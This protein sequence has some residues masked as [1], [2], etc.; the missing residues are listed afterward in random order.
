MAENANNRLLVVMFVAF[1]AILYAA[2]F[3][4]GGGQTPMTERRPAKDFT[5]TDL[6]GRTVSLSDYKGK[7]VFLNFWATWCG[8]CRREMPEIQSLH[9]KMDPEKFAVVTV[10][11]DQGGR[12][13]VVNFLNA[14]QLDVPVLLDPESRTPVQY[15]IT[16][17]PETFLIDKSGQMVERFIGPRHWLEENFLER[18]RELIDEKI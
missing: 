17:F 5:L 9:R 8:P 1:A 2:I 3:M 15:G 18:Y 4:T 16:A 13:D 6:S 14:R 10:S 12:E 11:V 7:V